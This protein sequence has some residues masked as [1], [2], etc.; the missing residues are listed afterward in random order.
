VALHEAAYQE[1]DRR[2]KL[3][4]QPLTYYHRTGPIGQ[5]MAA[6]NSDPKEPPPNIAVIGLGTGTMSCYARQ[7]QN[8]TFYDIDPLVRDIAQNW[9]YFTYWSDAV[10]RGA[11]LNLLINDARL[12]IERQVAENP[13]R[14]DAEKYKVMV[15]DA[16]S[17]DAIPIHLITR[18][19]LQLYL[20]MLRPDGIIA[21]HVS[22]RYL[23]LRPVLA[24]LAE[25][26]GLVGY[27]ESDSTG[28][29]AGKTSSTW[30][31]LTRSE[32][33]V[34]RLVNAERWHKACT[35]MVGTRDGKPV[36]LVPLLLACPDATGQL[37]LRAGALAFLTSQ[38]QTYDADT[39]LTT[40]TRAVKAPWQ[41]LRTSPHVGLW[42]DDFSNVLSIFQK[43]QKDDEDDR[44]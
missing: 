8:F 26:E 29:Y 14:P 21:F 16:F 3:L 5:I 9:D 41:R 18:E 13:D 36:G 42:T 34:A 38:H 43:W 2:Q 28:D 20:K 11:N 15:I 6:Y 7:G 19:A 24:R 1:W 27:T 30:V 44:P 12:A 40:A 37:A 4:E 32:E 23:D 25:A 22:N 39:K 31:I 35:E 17:S 33:A 10:E